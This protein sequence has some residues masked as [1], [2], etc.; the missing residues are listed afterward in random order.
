MVYGSNYAMQCFPAN[1]KRRQIC[2]HKPGR[3]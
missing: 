1:V 3:I 2:C